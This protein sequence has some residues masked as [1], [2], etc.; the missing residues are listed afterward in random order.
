MGMVIVGMVIVG[1]V[2]VIVLCPALASWPILVGLAR[3]T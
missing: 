3:V 2:V 1:M